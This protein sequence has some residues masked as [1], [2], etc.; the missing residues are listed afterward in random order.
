MPR[1][2]WLIL[3]GLIGLPL[4]A[5]IVAAGG[6][7]RGPGPDLVWGKRGQL[8]GDLSRPRAAAVIGDTL[9]VVDFTARVQGYD[10]DGNHTG[11]T[12]TP[13]DFRNGRPSGLGV[14]RDGNLIVCDSHYHCVRIYTLDG[15]ELRHFGEAGTE[16]GRFG[17]VS[18]CVQDAD[19]FF[20]VAEFGQNDRITKVDKAG[21][22][23]TAWG[24]SG[25]EP[26]R[27]Q[28][29]RALALGPDGNLYVCDASN[30]RVQVFTR[31]GELVRI[32]GGP[33][34]GPGEFHYPSDVAV[35]RDGNI[36]VVERVNCRVQKLSPEGKPLGMWGTG[37]R[38]PGQL[39]DPWALALDRFGRVHVIDTENH[40]VQRVRF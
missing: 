19:G 11:V 6:G 16:P 15:R 21:R 9:F 10:L 39:A 27:F 18:D 8:P 7:L 17:Y 3:G 1:S 32:I 33:G 20:Y 22:L 5:V 12:F 30:H 26:G 28:R 38:G 36:Y 40:R 23:V 35:D 31:D 24:G 4:V 29:V 13:P 14:T 34:S 2:N 37:G 25:V